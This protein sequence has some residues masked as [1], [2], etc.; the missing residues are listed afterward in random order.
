M[1]KEPITE[2]DFSPEVRLY[3][4]G[5]CRGNPGPGGWGFVMCHLKSGKELRESGGLPETTNNQ[6][7][8]TAVIEG[9]SRLKRPTKV[10]VVSD[11]TYV[12]NG[13]SSWME[14]WKKRGWRRKEGPVKNVEMWKK[15]DE[16]KQI[17]QLRF[18][19]IKGHNGHPENEEC[20][21]LAV[22]AS[23]KFK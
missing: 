7:E 10:E 1:K 11:S 4:D 22:E 2:E 9:L 15:L 14:S 16:F 19:W 17:H 8:L 18:T 23:L 6:M 20:D 21:R 3:T 13:L 5:A 12:L